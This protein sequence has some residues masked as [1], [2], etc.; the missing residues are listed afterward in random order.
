MRRDPFDRQITHAEW[1]HRHPLDAD[2]SPG[3]FRKGR[4]AHGCPRRCVY[5]R[6]RKS[7]PTRQQRIADLSLWEWEAEAVPIATGDA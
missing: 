5:C 2:L 1:R 7:E 6:L 4:R 3:Y